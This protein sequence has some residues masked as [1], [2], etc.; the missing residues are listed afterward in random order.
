MLEKNFEEKLREDVG[1]PTRDLDPTPEQVAFGREHFSNTYAEFIETFGYGRVRGGR[2]QFCPIDVFRPLAALIFK[3]DP[4]LS[5]NDCHIVGYDAFGRD[6]T[7]WSQRF[8]VVHVDLLQYK[9]RNLSLAPSDLGTMPIPVPVNP[10]P[11]NRE[12]RTRSILPS[13]ADIGECWDWQEGK[14][15]DRCV[16]GLGALEFGEVYGFVPSLGLTGYNTRS[17]VV[18]NVR[19]QRALEHFCMIAQLQPFRLVR[20]FGP[21]EETVREIG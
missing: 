6:V 11:L 12:T 3:A 7:V 4:E 21:R 1:L 5:H 19:R 18:E 8:N 2:F 16:K 13:T 9:I 10:V 15:F 17:R 20:N 14:M